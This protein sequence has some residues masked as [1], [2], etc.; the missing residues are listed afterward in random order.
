MIIAQ[1][2]RTTIEMLSIEDAP[3]LLNLVNSPAWLQSIGDRNIH[4]IDAAED[5]LRTGLLKQYDEKG[6]GYYL[7]R[8]KDGKSI[9]ICGFLKKPHLKNEDFGFAFAP[10]YLRQGYGFEAGLAT[11]E[12]GIQHFEFR[13]LDAETSAKNLASIRLLEKLGFSYFGPANHPNNPDTRLYRWKNK[14]DDTIPSIKVSPHS[15]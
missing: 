11:L 8:R 5:Y 15:T 14:S 3:F 13:E 1:T 2:E 4:R 10:E 6:Y 12:Y 9:G 7:V